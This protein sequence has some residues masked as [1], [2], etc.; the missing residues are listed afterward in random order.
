LTMPCGSN[1]IVMWL[2]SFLPLILNIPWRET[3]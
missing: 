2:G 3:A 1:N